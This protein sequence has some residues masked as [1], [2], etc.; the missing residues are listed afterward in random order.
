MKFVVT[1][2]TEEDGWGLYTQTGHTVENIKQ[3]PRLQALFDSFSVRPTYLITHPVAEDKD[4]IRILKSIHDAGKCEIGSHCHPWNTPPFEEEMN[5]P[6]SMLCNLPESLQYAKL[7][8][9]HALIAMNFGIEPKVFRAGRWGFDDAVGSN[10]HRLGYEVDTSVT[11]F[12]DWGEYGGPDFSNAP[13]DPYRIYFDGRVHGD[14]PC[15]LLEIPASVGFLQKNFALSHRV[16]KILKR[17]PFRHLHLIGLLNKIRLLN[18]VWLS[19][20]MNTSEDMAGLCRTFA[21]RGH[22]LLNVSFHSTS[23]LPKLSPFIPDQKA[24]EYF[25]ERIEAFLLFV[26]KQGMVSVTLSEV[27]RDYTSLE[28]VGSFS[29]RTS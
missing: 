24:V 13:V 17:D 8:N 27:A 28:N 29:A 4:S 9:L 22:G 26:K 12:F 10:I 25:Y 5:E 20:E 16:L 19:P 7:E 3:I 6:N 21:C 15:S 14:K 1:I 18:L 2:D 11:P 23:L